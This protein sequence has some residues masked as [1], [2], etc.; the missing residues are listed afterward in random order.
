[1]L[2][3]DT[4]HALM[5]IA[6]ETGARLAL[7]GD[8]HQLPAVGR[9]G[10]LDL[11][12]RWAGDNACLTL[13]RVHRFSDREYADL[14]LQMRTGDNPAGVFDA[15]LRRGE[16]VVHP[17]EVERDAALAG[18]GV[19]RESDL[20]ARARAYRTGRELPPDPDPTIGC[21]I[22]RNIFFAEP[23]GEWPQP[24]N[25]SSNVVTGMGYDLSRPQLHPDT[26][27]V[28]QAFAGLQSRARVDLAW[29]PDLAD[30]D[31]DWDGPRHGPPILVRPR[32]GQGHFKRA[33]AAAYGNR[34]AVTG[35]ATFP[36]LEAAHIRPFAA[37]G[38]HAVSN[39]L[40]L[41][42]DVHRLYDR[43]YLSVDPDLR[44]RVSPQ[45]REHG[46]NGVEFYA[47]E[48]EGFSISAP[49]DDRHKPDRAALDWHFTTVFRAA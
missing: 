10:V 7:V 27:Y 4:A 3:Q 48:A 33:V 31:L 38:M 35:S 49:P 26:D 29:E 9:G 45:L 5:T 44:L 1:M 2:D 12:V 6:D 23:G 20:V 11:A 30:I 13:D 43:G 18:A 21:V 24:P 41:R 25:W 47:R 17:S 22:L 42:T 8:R 16:I 32:M 34:C 15:L 14:S 40:F 37:G 46:W 39:G 28:Q 36:S 19:A